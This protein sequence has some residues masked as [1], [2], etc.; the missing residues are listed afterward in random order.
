MPNRPQHEARLAELRAMIEAAKQDMAPLQR[1]RD[2]ILATLRN[3]AWRK[4][5]KMGNT[6]G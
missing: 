6:E 1:E 2:K 5:K 3:D 4:R